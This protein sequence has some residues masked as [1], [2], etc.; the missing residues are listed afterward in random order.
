MKD[1]V[2]DYKLS[3]SQATTLSPVSP[4]DFDF[5]AFEDH[6]KQCLETC[7]E[8][9]NADQGILV[10]RRMR[11]AGVFSEG[12]RDMRQSLELQL[13][14]L[15][16][17]LDY[18]MDIPNFLEPWYGIGVTASSFGSK[19]FWE[20]KQAPAVSTEFD[21]TLD[22]LAYADVPVRETPIGRHVLEMIS[23]FLD[24]TDGRLPISLTDVQSPLNVASGIIDINRFFMDMVTAPEL[25]QELL[26]KIADRTVEFARDQLD[27]IGDNIV[28]P[29]HGFASCR[30]FEGIG[31]SDD[32]ILMLSNDMYRD[33]ACPSLNHQCAALGGVAFHSCGDWSRAVSVVKDIRD[34]RVADGAFTK[35][36][37]PDSNPPEMFSGEFANTGITLN[38]RMVGGAETVC[39]AIN[40]IWTPGTKMIAVT[41]CSSPDEHEQVYK[42]AKDLIS[43]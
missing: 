9:K 19:Y 7:A 13:G 17:G 22:A 43:G 39:K 38:A 36:T 29:G 12:C 33:L 14:G 32:L 25:V 16:A 5:A 42:Y 18:R 2:F 26:M 6:E 20:P 37:D 15:A 8:F 35:E 21:C 23:Y 24:A 41:N 3:D 31:A 34:I 40:A 1:R 11:V 28:W 30:T 10:H 4:A 27:I